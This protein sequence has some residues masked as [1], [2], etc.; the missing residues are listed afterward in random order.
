[1]IALDDTDREILRALRG[2][3]RLSARAVGDL[4]GL[5]QPAA[6]RR[7]DRLEKAGVFRRRTIIDPQKSGFTVAVFLGIKLAM[8]GRVALEDFER[9]VAAIP[10]V[11][12][13]QHV[14]GLYDYRV[15]II[16]RDL[17]DFNRIL[18]NQIMTLP[19][20]GDVESN[21]ILGTEKDSGPRL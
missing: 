1:M 21:V 6:W 9:A 11:A 17:D 19:G 7:M 12:L 4:V 20:V 18:H 14:L 10:E 2:D 5:S 16:A 13:V 3:G 15:K 8:R